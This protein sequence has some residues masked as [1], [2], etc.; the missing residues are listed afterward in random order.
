MKRFQ[1]YREFNNKQVAVL[2]FDDLAAAN[3]AFDQACTN[4]TVAVAILADMS[5]GRRLAKSTRIAA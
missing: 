4:N 2:R 5:I 3:A 1:L